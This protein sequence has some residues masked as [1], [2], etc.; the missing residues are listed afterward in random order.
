MG[1]FGRIPIACGV[2]AVGLTVLTM[3][4]SLRP[5]G[6]SLTVLPRV[7]SNTG[8]GDAARARDPG[9][10]T[11]HPGAYDGQFYWGIAVD[12]IA[13]GDV[14][15]HFDRASYRYG[16]PL[17]GWLGWLFSAGQAR[18]APYALAAVSLVSMLLAGILASLLG[19]T[20]GRE[21]WEGLFIA[22]NPGLLYAAAHT[23]AEPVCAALL[24]GGLLAYVRG[25]RNAALLCFALLPLS[26]EPLILVPFAI[27]AWGLLRRRTDLRGALVLAATALPAVVWW[28]WARVQLGAWFTAGEDTAFRSPL[29]G[30][31]RALLDAGINSFSSDPTSNQ[32]G[33]ATVV[34]LVAL[35]GLLLV[36]AL[37]SFRL[38]GPA[39]AAFLP[40]VALVACLSPAATVYER[41]VLRVTSIL[42]VLVP[43][44]IASPAVRPRDSEATYGS[45]EARR[46][47]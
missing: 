20:T 33:E 2:L 44:V 22:V 40:L 23:L 43:F 29:E 37:L 10:H 46:G 30:W 4:P 32:L 31:R 38:R 16:H 24:L 8:M 21:G 12:P 18:A 28:I 34:V 9:F 14:H 41:D 39:E 27:A 26:K 13:T 5:A 1:R 25:R 35:G 19:R 11:I 3:M 7:D 15:Q 17:Y 36:A 6:W 47:P 45:R 42:V